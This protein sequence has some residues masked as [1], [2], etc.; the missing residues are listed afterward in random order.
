MG[1]SIPKITL[2]LL[3]IAISIFCL[4]D[5]R[6]CP[7]T[8]EKGT[9]TDFSAPQTSVEL[10]PCKAWK[11]PTKLSQNHHRAMRSKEEIM[12]RLCLNI[13]TIRSCIFLALGLRAPFLLLSLSGR[14]IGRER[15][16]ACSRLLQFCI[17][18]R[19]RSG[20]AF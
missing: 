8:Q 19:A 16:F 2:V 5:R 20:R 11:S 7:W 3:L 15:V 17:F 14:S 18:Y 12:G 6:K 4:S 1:K 9:N 13:C 10:L